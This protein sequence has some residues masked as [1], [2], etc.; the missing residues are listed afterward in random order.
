MIEFMEWLR[1]NG[2]RKET[3][4]A[5]GAA[6]N[7]LAT[8]YEEQSDRAFDPDQVTTR[9]LHDWI[10]YMKTVQRR[11]DSTVNQR[12]AAIKTYWK[13]LMETEKTSLNQ[14]Q[15]IRMKRLSALNQ[16]PRWLP[17]KQQSD[18]LHLVKKEKNPWKRTRNLAIIQTMLQAGVRV[19]EAAALE[20]DDLDWKRKRLIIWNGKGGKTRRI[21]MNSD[22]IRAFKEWE[23]QRGDEPSLFLFLSNRG[24]DQM[25]RQ[26]IHYMIR[27]YFD[28]LGI[29]GDEFSTH[30]LR[31]SFCKNLIDA[32]SKD[33]Q[34]E[35]IRITLVAELAGHESLE[36]TRR[37]VT[38]SEQD[39]RRAIESISEEKE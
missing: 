4:D 38:P 2:K 16:A 37:Y 35:R 14:A 8:W 32:R 27:R 19:S 31:H 30:S 1:A 20:M 17:R 28:Q 9:D 12:V 15:P 6:V 13:F 39:R 22:L 5:Y 36:T 7:A 11:A 29:T 34:L 10:A 3:L 23:E 18:L 21:E 26:G 33:P 25:T 24:K